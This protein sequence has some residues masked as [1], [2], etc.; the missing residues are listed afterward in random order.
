MSLIG[1]TSRGAHVIETEDRGEEKIVRLLSRG[2]TERS[3]VRSAMIEAGNIIPM[4]QQDVLNISL[5]RN[6]RI[7][8]RY[9]ITIT[10][11]SPGV[12]RGY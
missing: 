12:D 11:N 2:I 8:K 9:L 6:L 1:F 5:D 10:H 3:A 7:G 4:P